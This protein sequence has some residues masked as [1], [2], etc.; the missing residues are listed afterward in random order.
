MLLREGKGGTVVEVKS[1]AEAEILL[2]EAFP[3]Y[4][5]IRGTGNINTD[6]GVSPTRKHNK[7]EEFKKYGTYHKDYPMNKETKRVFGHENSPHGEYPHI[8]IHREDG[9][10]VLINI[11]SGDSEVQ[12][13]LAPK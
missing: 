1:F 5:K 11:V 9:E 10:K 8:N 6:A 4:R 2:N 7:I 3:K 13:L 12:K